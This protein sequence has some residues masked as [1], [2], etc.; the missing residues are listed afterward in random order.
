VNRHVLVIALVVAGALGWAAFLIE[1]HRTSTAEHRVERLL[2]RVNGHCNGVRSTLEQIQQADH[3]GRRDIGATLY[4]LVEGELLP[5]ARDKAAVRAASGD[6]ARLLAAIPR[7]ELD[8]P[9]LA[10]DD[11]GEP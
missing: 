5:C 9:A 6:I 4:P 11:G 1:Q 8:D 2:V 10:A 3:E 7:R